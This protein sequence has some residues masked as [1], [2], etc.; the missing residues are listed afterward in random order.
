LTIPEGI[1]IPEGVP[2]PE[3]APAPVVVHQRRVRTHRPNPRYFGSEWLNMAKRQTQ[4][5]RAG[6]LNN[7]F[8]Q[9]LDW[10]DLTRSL[11]KEFR[12]FRAV[13]DSYTN[14]RTQ[15][16]ERWNSLAMAAKI[17]ASDSPRWHEAVNG[18]D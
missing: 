8:I 6:T 17:N 1:P 10:N 14:P 9:S 15:E 3:R 2:I 4:E 5:L 12:A 16:T 7:A 13:T 11:L 18:P